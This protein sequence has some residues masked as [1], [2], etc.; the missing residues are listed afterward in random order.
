MGKKNPIL[1]K[2]W[3]EGFH[4]GMEAGRRQAVLA[5]AERFDRLANTKGFGEKTM[6]KIIKVMELPVEEEVDDRDKKSR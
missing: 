6:E 2:K 5:F 3:N 1:Q 4:A